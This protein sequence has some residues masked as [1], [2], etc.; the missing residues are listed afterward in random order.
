VSLEDGLYL[1][2]PEYVRFVEPVTEF[3]G[4]VIETFSGFLVAVFVS[5][6]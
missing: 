3:S 4:F 5:D 1:L 2:S 6:Y